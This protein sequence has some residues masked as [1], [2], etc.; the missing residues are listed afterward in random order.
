MLIVSVRQQNMINMNNV[1]ADF[2]ADEST[3]K[4]YAGSDNKWPLSCVESQSNIK[5]GRLRKL[6]NL[7]QWTASTP[8]A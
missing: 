2:A 3:T 8:P 6:P 1:D 4:F 5:L 7:M